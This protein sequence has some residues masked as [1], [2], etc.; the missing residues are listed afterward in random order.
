VDGLEGHAAQHPIQIKRS[1][2]PPT[3]A[4]TVVVE[5]AGEVIPYVA[6]VVPEKAP[7]GRQGRRAAEA[8]EMHVVRVAGGEGGRPRRTSVE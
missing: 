2:A 1:T 5:R 3:R 4:I 7:K 8:K 6:E